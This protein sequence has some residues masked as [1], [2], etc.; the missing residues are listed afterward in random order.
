MILTG[1]LDRDSGTRT[2]AGQKV[3]HEKPE[4][5]VASVFFVGRDEGDASTQD[6]L[7]R[8]RDRVTAIGDDDQQAV[9][10]IESGLHG[11]I[12]A[13]PDHSFVCSLSVSSKVGV[14][15]GSIVT[16]ASLATLYQ[17]GWPFA[18]PSE[19][20]NGPGAMAGFGIIECHGHGSQPIVA[21]RYRG[22]LGSRHG[23][24]RPVAADRRGMNLFDRI[25]AGLD[26]SRPF[27]SSRSV[28]VPSRGSNARRLPSSSERT[29]YRDPSRLTTEV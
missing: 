28:P 20:T 3:P 9:A 17:W 2:E 7:D 5:A 25:G 12:V 4:C 26:G 15:I 24:D 14:P 8:R 11:H 6:F 10:C 23:K 22:R 13:G 29:T 27:R 16:A 18:P 1:P 19:N 21:G